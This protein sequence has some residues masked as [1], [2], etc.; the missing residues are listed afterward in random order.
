MKEKLRA[1]G[2][3]ERSRINDRTPL[4]EAHPAV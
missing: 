4:Q 2:V 3:M 1:V